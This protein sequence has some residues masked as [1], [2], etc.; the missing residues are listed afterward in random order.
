KRMTNSLALFDRMM[1]ARYASEVRERSLFAAVVAAA[2]RHGPKRNVFDDEAT[3]YRKLLMQVHMLAGRIAALDRAGNKPVGLMLSEPGAFVTSL[4]ALHS[5][6]RVA[7][8]LDAASGTVDTLAQARLA[9][10]RHVI[11]SRAATAQ[12]RLAET[13]EHLENEGLQILW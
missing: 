5:A 13:I 7:A 4:L 12:D 2:N 9:G 8:P 11:C 6:G 3:S 10:V 1:E